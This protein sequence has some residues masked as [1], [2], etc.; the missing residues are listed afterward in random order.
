MGIGKDED[1][2]ID[3]AG[4]GD[5]LVNDVVAAPPDGINTGDGVRGG[6]SLTELADNGL[7]QL[8]TCI[9]VVVA[10]RAPK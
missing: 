3:G 4:M 5:G 2:A 6:G 10:G 9:G 7:G 8:L 1:A